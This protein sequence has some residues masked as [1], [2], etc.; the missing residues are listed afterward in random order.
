MSQFKTHFSSPIAHYHQ[1]RI[2]KLR[3]LSVFGMRWNALYRQ[4]P[5]AHPNIFLSFCMA[6][7]LSCIFRR[8][9]CGGPRGKEAKPTLCVLERPPGPDSARLL[10]TYLFLRSPAY[11]YFALL[12]ASALAFRAR[13]FLFFA[14]RLLLARATS[15]RL[16]C[17]L[18]SRQLLFHFILFTE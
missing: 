4:C 5:S 11:S 14:F 2:I 15:Y 6:Q 3:V 7:C 10:E 13:A 17:F 18:E 12:L 8:M 1:D 16:T 9:S